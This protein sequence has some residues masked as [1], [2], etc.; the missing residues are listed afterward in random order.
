M[1][2]LRAHEAREG[3]VQRAEVS[4]CEAL[5]FAMPLTHNLLFIFLQ[6][7]MMRHIS[8]SPAVRARAVR[9]ADGKPVEGIDSVSF[10]HVDSVNDDE[11]PMV[12]NVA[13]RAQVHTLEA[14]T[15]IN[16]AILVSS[17]SFLFSC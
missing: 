7:A 2:A 11:A 5:T 12:I 4:F 13:K 8:R 17:K 3:D 9:I 15:E 1:A 16:E 10:I 6:E 14:T